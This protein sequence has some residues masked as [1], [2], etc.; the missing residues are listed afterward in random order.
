MAALA[1][2]PPALIVVLEQGW[3][4]SGYERHRRFPELQARLDAAYRLD[5]D[6]DGFRIYAKRARP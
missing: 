6:G 4:P 5:H 2:T 1:A 3:P